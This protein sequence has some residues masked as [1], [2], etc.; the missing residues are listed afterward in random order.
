MKRQKPMQPPCTVRANDVWPVEIVPVLQWR[1]RQLRTI[2]DDPKLQY[3][4]I[5]YYSS[6]PVEFVN[7]W[8]DT[9]DPRNLSV[10][11][12]ARIP[13][14]LFERQEQLIRFFLACIRGQESG[15]VEKCRDMGATWAAVGFTAWLFLFWPGASI[16]WG[17][18]KEMLVDRLGDPDSIFEKIRMVVGG[19]PR[20]FLPAG[21][22]PKQHSHYMRIVNP[23]NKSTITGEAG[24]NIGRGGR[25]TIYFKDESAHYERPE[26]VEAAL[27]DNTRVQIDISSVNGPMNVFHRKRE[28]AREWDGGEVEPG[29]VSLFVMDWS[30]H[31]GKNRAW[32]EERRARAVADGLL[33]VFEQEV[34]RNYYAAVE[35]T[36][37]D[38]EWFDSCVGAHEKLNIEV[39]GATV[40]ALDVADE[41]GDRNAMAIRRGILLRS[42][43]DWSQGNTGET[44]RRAASELEGLGEVSVQ[45]DC[46]GVGAGVKSEAARL[47][48]EGLM[49][50]GLRFVPWNAGARVER[51]DEH[52]D[53]DDHETPLNRDFFLNLI[54]QAWWEL[55][56]RMERTHRAVTEGLEF[57]ADQMMSIDPGMKNLRGLKKELC[58]PTMSRNASMKMRVNKK[59]EGSASPNRADAVVMCYFPLGLDSYSL[60]NI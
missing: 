47:M 3:G 41:G 21:F 27:G 10:G 19:L 11:R 29:Q 55:R 44:T 60:E 1:Q 26:Q 56:R 39:S 20:F 38:P 42:A 2:G 5:C 25:K 48:S 53:P 33:H 30:D 34:N 6:R 43:N 16:G 57:D 8:V 58:Q 54:A 18:R 9:Y 4:A 35:G 59:P 22:D 14:V 40:A 51:P 24:T 37:I 7:H 36:I 15:I 46:I 28:N 12:P 52:L 31:P 49:P 32:Y 45:Y 50:K 13:F 23:E 17:S